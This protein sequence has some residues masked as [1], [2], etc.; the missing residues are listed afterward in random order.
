[1]VINQINYLKDHFSDIPVGWS[2]HEDPDDVVTVQMAVAKGATI[3][4][5]HVGKNT[6]SYKLNAYS[7]TPEPVYRWIN[8]YRDAVGRNGRIHQT[9]DGGYFMASGYAVTKLDANGDIEWDAT[10][11]CAYC[12]EKYFDNGYVKG[13]NFDM[14][15]I[16]GGAIITGYGTAGDI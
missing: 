1:M 9:D 10:S 7:S 12:F 8:A 11:N 3:F 4:E 6:S 5:R 15:K 16:E 13:V 2:T 14:R